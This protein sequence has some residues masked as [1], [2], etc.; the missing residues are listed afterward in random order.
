MVVPAVQ[1]RV[2]QLVMDQRVPSGTPP[3]GLAVEVV[4]LVASPVV[5]PYPVMEVRMELDRAAPS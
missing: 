5:Q 4:V 3:M 1:A 2:L